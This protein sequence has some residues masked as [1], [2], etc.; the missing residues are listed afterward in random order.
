MVCTAWTRSNWN[1]WDRRTAAATAL[2]MRFDRGNGLFDGNG[3]WTGA[4]ALTAIID[5]ARRS[6]MR[7]YDYAIATTYDKQINARQGQFR[8]E[9]LDDTGWWGL[10]WV[11][12]YDAITR[13]LPARQ[14]ETAPEGAP[15]SRE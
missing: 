7:S 2:M 13:R 9:F 8:N 11:A 10:A 15:V 3:W 1:A 5:N 12:A 6:G 14:P 4:N